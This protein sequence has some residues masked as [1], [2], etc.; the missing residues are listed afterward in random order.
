[1]GRGLGGV[2]T[3]GKKRSITI[4]T[5]N[6]GEEKALDTY[7]LNFD[8]NQIKPSTHFNYDLDTLKSR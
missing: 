2:F 3:K 4:Y 6:E 5:G 8:G 7:N 1:M